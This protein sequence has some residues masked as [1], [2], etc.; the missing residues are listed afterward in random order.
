MA[1]GKKN[2]LK[3]ETTSTYEVPNDKDPIYKETWDL[4]YPL[5]ASK[6]NFQTAHLKQ[7]EILCDLY[8]DQKRLRADIDKNGYTYVAR[9]RDGVLE[10]PR[11]QVVMLNRVRLDIKTYSDM[12]ELNLSKDKDRRPGKDPAKEPEWE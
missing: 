6:K 10:R 11:P 8:A 9:L 3:I 12:L 4:L 1:R 2:P 7:L 5:L